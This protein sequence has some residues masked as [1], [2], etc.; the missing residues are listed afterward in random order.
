MKETSIN[1]DH[2]SL[3]G[4][5]YNMFVSAPEGST[6]RFPLNSA[7]MWFLAGVILVWNLVLP[8]GTTLFKRNAQLIPQVAKVTH[9]QLT[10][11]IYGVMSIHNF[12][13]KKSYFAFFVVACLAMLGRGLSTYIM[14]LLMFDAFNPGLNIFCLVLYFSTSFIHS[15][16]DIHSSMASSGGHGC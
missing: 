7:N 8:L 12:I 6:P 13:P 10:K 9:D 11:D 4:L 1:N 5:F 15:M 2:G 14:N 16:L 3:F